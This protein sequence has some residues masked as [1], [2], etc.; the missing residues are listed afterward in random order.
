[1][2]MPQG[3]FYMFP[4]FTDVIPQDLQGESRQKYV[5]ELLMENGIASVY[6]AC[7]GRHFV[8]NVR[9]SFSATPVELIEE[10]SGR[11]QRIFAEA[12]AR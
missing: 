11:L 6:G 4:N 7:F 1:M 2:A 5:Y 9:L 8:D 3:A 12:P 10:A